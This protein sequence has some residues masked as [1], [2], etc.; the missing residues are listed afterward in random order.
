V[1]TRDLAISDTGFVFDP[2]GGGVFTVNPTARLALEMLSRGEPP[3]RVEAALRASFDAGGA[4]V[5][6][7][8]LDFIVLLREQRLLPDEE[9]E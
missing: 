8:L 3:D 1:G 5:G 6:R 4:D 7:D 2:M 9:A